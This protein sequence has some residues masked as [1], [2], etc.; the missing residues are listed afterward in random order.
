[1]LFR[2][3]YLDSN[4]NFLCKLIRYYQLL[5]CSFS[6]NKFDLNKLI[7]LSDSFTKLLTKIIVKNKLSHK[8]K[9]IIEELCHNIKNIKITLFK[10]KYK[11]KDESNDSNK[12]KDEKNNILSNLLLNN[13]NEIKHKKKETITELP[14]LVKKE[15]HN[16]LEKLKKYHCEQE[17]HY[18]QKC[19]C[20]TE[21][22]N[23]MFH[24]VYAIIDQILKNF[25]LMKCLSNIYYESA[26][27]FLGNFTVYEP[28]KPVD[29]VDI[30]LYNTILK[31]FYDKI[32]CAIIEIRTS[33]KTFLSKIKLKINFKS[34]KFC[35]LFN[36]E[37][38]E[39]IKCEQKIIIINSGELD[40]VL[41]YL[42]SGVLYEKM[43][44]TIDHDLCNIHT[45]EKILNANILI[46][47]QD[48]QTIESF[49]NVS[50]MCYDDIII[51]NHCI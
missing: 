20:H 4:E 14:T 43:F 9:C 29:A 25:H 44:E 33:I 47:N 41:S 36:I 34:L 3:R 45:L 7:K 37:L 30:E 8:N 19:N 31:N 49:K 28:D 17:C 1:M 5:K 38:K 39:A 48:L 10:I 27:K 32:K 6:K 13:V 16:V 18:E 2:S 24:K 15:K 51:E 23:H 11:I 46:I 40:I 21:C 12:S 26:R 42:S 50:H 22:D 35:E